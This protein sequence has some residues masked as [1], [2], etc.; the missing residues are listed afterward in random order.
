MSPR[1]LM[2]GERLQGV[3]AGFN[4]VSG[5]MGM[6]A[7]GLQTGVASK[8]GDVEGEEV[9]GGSSIEEASATA[10]APPSPPGQSIVELKTV[11]PPRGA[12]PEAG[13]LVTTPTPH[14]PP[15][16]PKS[17]TLNPTPKPKP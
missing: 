11:P 16:N 6:V 12:S 4:A 17:S 7:S 8:T 15:F 2:R 14:P 13:T 5:A 9:S 1:S 3:G 10:A